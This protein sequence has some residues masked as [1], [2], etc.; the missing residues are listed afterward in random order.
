MIEIKGND[1]KITIDEEPL[2]K[3]IAYVE[4]FLEYLQEDPD[5]KGESAVTTIDIF[6]TIIETL[7]AFWCEHFSE[8]R[9]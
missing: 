4:G 5:V 1:V 2:L 7:Q 8:K 3:A 6:R 9:R